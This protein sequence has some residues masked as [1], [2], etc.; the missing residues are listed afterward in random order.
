MLFTRVALIAQPVPPV[1]PQFSPRVRGIRWTN[2]ARANS[3]TCSVTEPIKGA[4]RLP[5]VGKMSMSAAILLQRLG[6][7]AH[8]GNAGLF[9]GIHHGCESAK[10]Y[11][12]V[13]AHEDRLALRIADL[14]MQLIADLVN[15]DGLVIEKDTLLAINGDH[16]AFLG[17]LLDRKAH[18]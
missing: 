14:L 9:H 13:G 10:R 16:Q 4:R 12:F 6:H 2:N 3:A 17:D 1:P 5:P 11:I 8:V 15:V 7:D 18:V